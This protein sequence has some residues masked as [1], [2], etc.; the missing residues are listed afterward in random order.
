MWG[1]GE[2]VVR[3]L[4]NFQTLLQLEN[5]IENYK[6]R[7][8]PVRPDELWLTLNSPAPHTVVSILLW[9]NYFL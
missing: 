7:S 8:I 6:M 4:K 9:D 3:P 5:Y 2:V 1:G